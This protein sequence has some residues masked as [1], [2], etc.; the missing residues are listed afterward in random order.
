MGFFLSIMFQGI[1]TGGCSSYNWLEDFEM[2]GP[3]RNSYSYFIT[4]VHHIFCGP[5]H[6]CIKLAKNENWAIKNFLMRYE[7]PCWDF[8]LG[9]HCFI[10]LGY[11]SMTVVW[12]QHDWCYILGL[13]LKG[14][15][16]KKLEVVLFTDTQCQGQSQVLIFDFPFTAKTLKT[17]ASFWCGGGNVHG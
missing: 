3:K 1:T 2:P 4:C 14:Y 10:W 7:D 9:P 5:S 6:S 16:K 15:V 11:A 12:M 13:I 17:T 8:P